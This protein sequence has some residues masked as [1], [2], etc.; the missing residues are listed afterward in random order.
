MDYRRWARHLLL[1][2]V[3]LILIYAFCQLLP[4]K[5]LMQALSIGTAYTS[6]LYFAVTLSIGP[7]NLIRSRRNPLSSLLRRDL[8][9]WSGILAL[10]HTITGLQ[11]HFKGRL[12][13]YFIYPPDESHVLPFRTDPFGLTN[14]IGLISALIMIAL[15]CLSNNRSIRIM[16]ASS[17]K[18]WHRLAYVLVLAIPA[19]GLVYQL[20][21]KR[22][23]A[24]TM[25]LLA[26]SSV[27]VAVQISGFLRFRRARDSRSLTDSETA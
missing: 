13:Q 23:G 4:D 20:L 19:H 22:I 26:I 16:G 7:V 11:V 25:L 10:A 12:I 14:Y 5:P 15:L 2:T 27:I 1:F 8:G 24:Y 6:L 21:E 18:K 17:W 9:I 3:A